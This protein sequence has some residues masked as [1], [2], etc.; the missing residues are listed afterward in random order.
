[1][2]RGRTASTPLT[3]FDIYFERELE[4][5][6][7]VLPDDPIVADTKKRNK[8]RI[9]NGKVVQGVSYRQQREKKLA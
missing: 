7:S 8:R 5:D 3:K 2:E 6:E 9:V 4:R 1:M